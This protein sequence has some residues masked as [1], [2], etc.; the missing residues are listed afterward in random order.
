[1]C[2]FVHLWHK[3]DFTSLPNSDSMLAAGVV[4]HL[5]ICQYDA[6]SDPRMLCTGAETAPASDDSLGL[7]KCR[8]AKTTARA[9]LCM[10]VS[11]AVVRATLSEK[12]NALGTHQPKRKPLRGGEQRLGGKSR[13]L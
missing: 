4:A 5:D 7:G 12:P 6:T 8:W 11:T 9:L 10:P 2:I 3:E 13:R 1:M